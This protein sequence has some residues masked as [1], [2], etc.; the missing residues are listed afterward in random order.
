VTDA[1]VRA[2]R[3]ADRATWQPLWD[4]YLR[5]YRAQL[6]PDVTDDVFARL[7]GE[8]D[9]MFGLLAEAAGVAIGF[10]H[11]VVHASTWTRGRYAYLEDLYVAPAARGTGA[12]TKLIEAVYARADALGAPHVYWHTQEFNAPARSLYDQVARRTSFIVYER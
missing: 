7:C 1:S 2:L 5:F 12:A 3:A 11:V 9:G 4:G 10:A 8:R 6:E